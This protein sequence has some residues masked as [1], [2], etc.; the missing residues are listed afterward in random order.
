MSFADRFCPISADDNAAGVA[1]LPTPDRY[2]VAWAL[3]A[4]TEAEDAGFLGSHLCASAIGWRKLFPL[5]P[6]Q[7]EHLYADGTEAAAWLK[8]KR[9]A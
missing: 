5:S 3:R 1:V 8:A 6:A 4:L 2:D 7:L 9:E